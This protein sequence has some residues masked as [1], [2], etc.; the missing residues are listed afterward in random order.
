MEALLG[1]PRWPPAVVTKTQPKHEN[2]SSQNPLNKF[3]T[4]SCEN[5]PQENLF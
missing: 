4:S 2:D 3:G 1:S 5:D